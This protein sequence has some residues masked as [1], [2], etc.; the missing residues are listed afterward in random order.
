MKNI[1]PLPFAL[2]CA[3]VIQSTLTGCGLFKQAAEQKEKDEIEA[4]FE[5]DPTP[6][7]TV[8][9]VNAEDETAKQLQSSMEKHSQLILLKDQLPDGIVGL[10]RRAQADQKTALKLLRSLGYYDG[11]AEIKITEPEKSP[12]SAKNEAPQNNDE[13]T[14]NGTGDKADP[15]ATAL[16]T[17]TPNTQYKIGRI[18]FSYNPLPTPFPGDLQQKIPPL[19]Q[20]PEG[21]SAGDPVNSE[22]ILNAVNSVPQQLILSGYPYA[23]IRSTKYMLDKASKTLD[24]NVECD[25]GKAA[26]MGRVIT[27]GSKKVDDEYIAKLSTWSSPQP[28]DNKILQKYREKLQ[29]SGLFRTVDVK[30]AP[31]EQGLLLE[32]GIL[33]LPA[34]VNVEDAS[35]K[36]I[37]GSIKYATDT[38]MAVQGEWEHRNVFGAGEKINIKVPF[39]QE[40][41]GVQA[42]FEKPCFGHQDQKFLA[43]TSYLREDTDAYDQTALNGYVG[44]ERKI[45]EYWWAS[46]KLFAEKGTIT[47]DDKKDY[48]YGSVIFSLKR[49]T[50]DNPL[51]P[52]KGTL[53]RWDIAPTSGYYDGN[54]T[55]VSAKMAFSAY[56]SLFKDDFLVLAGRVAFGSF[57]GANLRNIPPSLRFYSGGGGSVRGYAYQAIGPR[58]S[59]DDPLGGRSFQEINLEAR[60]RVTKSFGIVPFLD[61]GMVYKDECPKLFQDLQWAAGIGFRYYTSIGPIRFDVAVPLNKKSGDN[62][63]QFYISI[64]QA[65]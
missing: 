59:H 26:F 7:E 2:L 52:V 62:G 30:P 50:R 22:T 56:Q 53:V 5:T 40:K 31:A 4:L 9:R 37:A 20:T 39:A 3:L 63:Y 29:H 25:P 48:H 11:T 24:V 54:F 19:P 58:D 16:L 18:N 12:G 46:G 42:D 57:I 21:I 6:Y 44:L 10:T 32:N 23:K 64:G 17:L 51:D 60:F 49:D 8:I 14:A 43:G 55:G 33:E 1:S 45:S 13:G 35:F 34:L 47:K 61:G 27:S 38:G 41:R 65:F 28:W 36:T 15:P